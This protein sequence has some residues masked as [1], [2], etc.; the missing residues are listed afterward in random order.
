MQQQQ[1]QR[2]ATLECILH[3][4]G[5]LEREA[6]QRKQSQS[7]WQSGRPAAHPRAPVHSRVV[8]FSLALPGPARQRRPPGLALQS[9][10]FPRKS[11][12]CEAGM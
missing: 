10:V 8:E 4:K 2:P 7:T 9:P 1:Q 3:E 6:G 12:G 5:V 11:M